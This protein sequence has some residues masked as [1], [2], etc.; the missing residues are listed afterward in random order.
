[1]D[2]SLFEKSQLQNSFKC[3]CNI[4]HITS[5]NHFLCSDIDVKNNFKILL[6]I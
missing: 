6:H 4:R 2:L 5:Q 1:M 3:L